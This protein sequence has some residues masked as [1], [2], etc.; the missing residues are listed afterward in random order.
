MG[1]PYAPF[2]KTR[3]ERRAMLSAEPKKAGSAC[4]GSEAGGACEKSVAGMAFDEVDDEWCCCVCEVEAG[5]VPLEAASSAVGGDE[6][7]PEPGATDPDKSVGPSCDA[8]GS[9]EWCLA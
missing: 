3:F 6:P 5:V 4:D 8:S 1:M 2:L 7:D 9:E